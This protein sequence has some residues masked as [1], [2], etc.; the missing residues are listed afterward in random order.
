MSSTDGVS[1][2][3]VSSRRT[4][5]NRARTIDL[6]MSGC[7]TESV[8]SFRWNRPLLSPS[9]VHPA[10]GVHV[11]WEEEVRSSQTL[12]RIRHHEQQRAKVVDCRVRRE[13][14]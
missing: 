3:R 6:T 8:G 12:A 9:G 2:I 13:E 11:W 7:E 4:E 1:R 14:R 5:Q 10:C